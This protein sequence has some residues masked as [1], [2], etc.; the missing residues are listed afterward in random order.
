MNIETERTDENFDIVKN[1]K[2]YQEACKKVNEY[3]TSKGIEYCE[4]D[5]TISDSIIWRIEKLT[6]K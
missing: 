3:L 1:L 2:Q 4:G 5:A 6:T